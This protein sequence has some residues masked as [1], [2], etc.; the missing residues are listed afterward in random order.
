MARIFAVNTSDGILT[1]LGT[2]TAQRTRSCWFQLNES[3]GATT[4]YGRLWTKG[5]AAAEEQLRWL[6][7]LAQLEFRFNWTGTGIWKITSPAINAWHHLCVTY[8]YG[9]ASNNPTIYLDG[10]SQSLTTT[11]P[12]GSVATQVGNYLIG[13][14]CTAPTNSGAGSDLAEFALWDRL[15]SASE[16][17]ALAN[18]MPAWS[19]P[20]SLVCYLPLTGADTVDYKSGSNTITGTTV[21]VLDPPIWR[22]LPSALGFQPQNNKIRM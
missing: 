16:I 9:S 13:N 12:T 5:G 2:T 4:N 17:T 7:D 10:V 19:F 14:S 6:D 18:G 11:A 15:L 20:S 8:D 22:P 1:G 3:A 21:Q